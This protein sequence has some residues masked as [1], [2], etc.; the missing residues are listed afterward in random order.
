[1]LF[2]PQYMPR[3]I[4]F[5]VSAVF[6]YFIVSVLALTILGVIFVVNEPI[7]EEHVA[8]AKVHRKKRCWN[9]YSQGFALQ[10][11]YLPLGKALRLQYYS[12]LRKKTVLWVPNALPRK[13]KKSIKM[14]KIKQG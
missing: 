8:V 9:K 7:S 5:A 1:M 13:N 3:N 10:R 11:L 2:V 12:L 6:T 14:T 4:I